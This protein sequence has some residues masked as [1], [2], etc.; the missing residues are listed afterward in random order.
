MN[1]I[2]IITALT[3]LLAVAGCASKENQG[4]S[5]DNANF[6]TGTSESGT[7]NP[8]PTD[9]K[10]NTLLQQN[11]QTTNSI[12]PSDNGAS[13]G[14][15]APGGTGSGTSTGSPNGTSN[16]SSSGLNDNSS[17]TNSTGQ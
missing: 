1:K 13:G 12:A 10:D 8:T 16:P 9:K 2:M 11:N 3:G 14:A 7:I 4:G 6:G 15:T 17:S 5:F